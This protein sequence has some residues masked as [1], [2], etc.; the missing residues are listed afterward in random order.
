MIK[1]KWLVL[2]CLAMWGAQSVAAA[3][4]SPWYVGLALGQNMVDDVDWVRHTAVSGLHGADVALR[5]EMG[6]GTAPVIQAGY[7]FNPAWSFE[8]EYARRSTE[9][10][11]V[12]SSGGKQASTVKIKVDS[13]MLN[14]KHTW[15]GWGSVHPF[16]GLGVGGAR[17]E[18]AAHDSLGQAS[19]ATW[20][21]AYQALLGAQWQLNDRWALVGQYQHF[22]VSSPHVAATTH[23][24]SGS[25]RNTWRPGRYTAQTVSLG[26][27][28]SF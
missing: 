1:Q 13:L 17:I 12:L 21:L 3:E 19:D 20:A 27:Q 28:F 24:A 18:G 8:T 15:Q 11:A 16:V 22:R 4:P 5:A 6:R 25:T 9:S 2:A 26:V 10:D 23:N 7:R 14:V